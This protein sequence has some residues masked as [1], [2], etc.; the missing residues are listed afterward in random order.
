MQMDAESTIF[1]TSPWV[2]GKKFTR[3]A[4]GEHLDLWTFPRR[5]LNLTGASGSKWRRL[6]WAGAAAAPPCK[7]PGQE[8]ALVAIASGERPE[9]APLA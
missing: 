4:S 7:V 3:R 8:V 6:A 1:V 2:A 9:C 5:Y